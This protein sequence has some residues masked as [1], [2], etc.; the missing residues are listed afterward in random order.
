MNLNDLITL[1]LFAG[2]FGMATGV[3][4]F[5]TGL[6]HGRNDRASQVEALRIKN[7][8]LRRENRDLRAK[9]SGD[10]VTHLS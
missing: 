8:E 9:L 1:G 7:E 4:G 3:I 6:N 5:L 10:F 2:L